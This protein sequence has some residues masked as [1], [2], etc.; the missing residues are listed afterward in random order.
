MKARWISVVSIVTFAALLAGAFAQVRQVPPPAG[1]KVKA[2]QQRVKAAVG[3]VLPW[4]A[5]AGKPNIQ[6]GHSVGFYIWHEGNRVIIVTTSERDKGVRFNGHVHVVGG[7]TISN[8]TGFKGEKLDKIK[9]PKPNAVNF[10]FVTH[11]AIDGISFTITGGKA[12]V[13]ALQMAGH[14]TTHKFVGASMREAVRA[15]I[16]FDFSK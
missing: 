12:A 10:R 14:P 15:P 13:F 9:Q 11:E 8:V 6:P 7:G 4:S 3:N 1:G 16:T 5:A 2:R